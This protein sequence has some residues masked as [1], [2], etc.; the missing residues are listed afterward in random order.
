MRASP[1]ATPQRWQRGRSPSRRE[2]G[3]WEVGNRLEELGGIFHRD[4]EASCHRDL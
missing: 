1:L 4:V 2:E 3:G